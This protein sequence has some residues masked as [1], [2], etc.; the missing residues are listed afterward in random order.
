MCTQKDSP[1]MDRE[2]A[3]NLERL[4]A[5]KKNLMARREEIT[6]RIEKMNTAISILKR[7]PELDVLLD[8]FGG[9]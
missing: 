1:E 5:R 7:K 3:N 9:V 2:P 8:A 6:L 4:I